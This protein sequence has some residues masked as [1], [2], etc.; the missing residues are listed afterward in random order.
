MRANPKKPAGGKTKTS[1]SGDC[2]FP[3]RALLL[4]E[5]AKRRARRTAKSGQN[6]KKPVG[7]KIEEN[8]AADDL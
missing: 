5:M 1:A 4:Y 8:S 3:P 2:C 7:G 6:D